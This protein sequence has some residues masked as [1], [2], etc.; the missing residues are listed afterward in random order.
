MSQDGNTTYNYKTEEI[1]FN[2]GGKSVFGVLY[3]PEGEQG[4]WPLAVFS[5]GFGGSYRDGRDYAQTL[6]A[7]GYAVVCYDFCGGSNH[8][9]SDGSTT[10]MSI[11]TEEQDLLAVVDSLKAMPFIDKEKIYLLGESQG[12]MVSALA[13]A[14]RPDDFRSV[15]LMYPALCIPDNAVEWFGTADNIPDTYNLWGVR[16]GRVYFERLFGFDV[17]DHISRY[18]GP[19]LLVHGDRDGVV[20]LRYSQQAAERYANAELHII[21][22][23]G[24]GFGGKDFRQSLE[25][26]VD[27]LNRND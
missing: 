3:R 6:A 14:D 13:A 26:V 25:Y 5:H 17:F 7:K 15:M 19:V 1:Y 10:E 12:G 4:Q 27:F 11:F 22:G 2:N 21:Q 16:L 8:S 18:Q 20:P 9:R 23:A 24:H